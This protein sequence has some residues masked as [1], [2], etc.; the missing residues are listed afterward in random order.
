MY[1]STFD[2]ICAKKYKSGKSF[3]I[4]CAQIVIAALITHGSMGARTFWYSAKLLVMQ[5]SISLLLYFPKKI[6]EKTNITAI[7]TASHLHDQS[8]ENQCVF[9][10]EV[11]KTEKWMEKLALIVGVFINLGAF[12]I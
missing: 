12:H 11:S 2:Q 3:E 5:L 1:I 10:E 4:K 9:V 6:C 7:S 8:S